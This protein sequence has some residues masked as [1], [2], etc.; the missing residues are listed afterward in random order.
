MSKA[1]ADAATLK[2]HENELKTLSSV[3]TMLVAL[4]KASERIRDDI[5]SAVDNSATIKGMLDVI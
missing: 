4:Q 3:R 5:A 1:K 2:L